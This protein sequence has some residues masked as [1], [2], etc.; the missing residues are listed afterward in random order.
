MTKG[1]RVIFM[2]KFPP[3]FFMEQWTFSFHIFSICKRGTPGRDQLFELIQQAWSQ[4]PKNRPSFKEIFQTLSRLEMLGDDLQAASTPA[5][6]AAV[7][8]AV[9][10]YSMGSSMAVGTGGRTDL[11]HNHL[12]PQDNRKIWKKQS[13]DVTGSFNPSFSQDTTANLARFLGVSRDKKSTWQGGST[14][15]RDGGILGN[16]SNVIREDAKSAAPRETT[17]SSVKAGGGIPAGWEIPNAPQGGASYSVAS[18]GN[19]SI[20]SSK[21][22]AMI[23]SMETPKNMPASYLSDYF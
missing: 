2:K 21:D 4:I 16:K 22:D 20:N 1:I 19:K 15:A 8:A 18:R 9:A 3:K 12:Q 6:A 5:T 23:T 14:P 17:P 11:K 7:A 10:A 13:E